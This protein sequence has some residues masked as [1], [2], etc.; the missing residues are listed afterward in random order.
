MSSQRL[1]LVLVSQ[2]YFN[3]VK[4]LYPVLDE[5]I[6]RL[7]EDGAIVLAAYDINVLTL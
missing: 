4:A 7:T 2:F 6:F 3:L 1:L 5:F